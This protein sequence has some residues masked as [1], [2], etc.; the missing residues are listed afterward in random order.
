MNYQ[1][2]EISYM[3]Y[4]VSASQPSHM[5]HISPAVTGGER[6]AEV[7]TQGYSVDYIQAHPGHWWWG[8]I[9]KPEF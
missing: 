6:A 7:A 4:L 3:K 2:Y 5:V 1:N 8:T 9:W